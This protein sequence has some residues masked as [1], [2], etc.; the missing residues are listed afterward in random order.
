VHLDNLCDENDWMTTGITYITPK[1][2]DSKEV[3]NYRPIACLMTTY[4][5]PAGI[6]AKRISPC[7]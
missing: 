1:S 7:K 4:R 2:G 3:R 5:T 6:V